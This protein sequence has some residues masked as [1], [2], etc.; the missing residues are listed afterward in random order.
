MPRKEIRKEELEDQWKDMAKSDTETRWEAR[1]QFNKGE[2]R[3]VMGN[4]EGMEGVCEGVETR[5]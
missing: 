3:K 5:R 1:S 4:D 2:R